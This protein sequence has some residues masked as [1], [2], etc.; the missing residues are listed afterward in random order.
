MEVILDPVKGRKG[1]T[2]VT[3]IFPRT[4]SALFW[5]ANLVP[6]FVLMFTA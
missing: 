1:V 4:E 2:F 5:L 3:G 6:V